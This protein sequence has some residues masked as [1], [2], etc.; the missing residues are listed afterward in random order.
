MTTT[1]T[2]TTMSTSSVSNSNMLPRNQHDAVVRRILQTTLMHVNSMATLPADNLLRRFASEGFKQRGN[3]YT[4]TD[5][6]S[7]GKYSQII[8]HTTFVMGSTEVKSW[9]VEFLDKM[10]MP[11]MRRMTFELFELQRRGPTGRVHMMQRTGSPPYKNLVQRVVSDTG[12]GF[13]YD[14]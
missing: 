5:H 6:I 2:T 12:L 8:V 7:T 13:V 1:T 9:A 11:G 10:M 4:K 3:M 14:F